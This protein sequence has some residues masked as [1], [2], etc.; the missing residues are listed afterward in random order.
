MNLIPNWGG[1]RTIAN[2]VAEA[3]C[4]AAGIRTG[5]QHPFR[6]S[7]GSKVGW[8]LLRILKGMLA[9]VL[10]A[11]VDVKDLNK[12]IRSECCLMALLPHMA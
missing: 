10:A 3:R 12:N 9:L 1:G 7:V 11:I 6:R 5:D 2:D 8:A 4:N